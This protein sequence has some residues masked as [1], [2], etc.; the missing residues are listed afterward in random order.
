MSAK[1]RVISAAILAAAGLL[2]SAEANADTLVIKR[3]GA[4]PNYRFEAEPHLVIGALPAPGPA[5][6]TG[7]GIGF[8]G[9]VELVDN[10]F[11]S[12]INNTV[13]VGFGADW[14]HYGDSDLPCRKAANG[15]SCAD[16]NPDFSLNYLY[17]PVVMQWNFWLSRNW[18]VF[19]EPGLSLRYASRGDDKL[20]LDPFVIFVGGRF[21]FSDRVTL[22]MRAGYPTFSVGAS[23]LL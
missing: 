3:P 14:V 21:H 17:L 12:Q 7:F 16:L 9:A 15:S 11:V 10:G 23:F 20:S 13:A 5:R 1:Q 8:R 22:T 4:H 2:W 6:D 19:G 18:S